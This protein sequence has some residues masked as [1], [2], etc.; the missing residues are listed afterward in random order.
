MTHLNYIPVLLWFFEEKVRSVL[1]RFLPFY[2][3]Y[4]TIGLRS[5]NS[6]LPA[7]SSLSRFLANCEESSPRLPCAPGDFI[8]RSGAEIADRRFG[9]RHAWRQS[10]RATVYRRLCGNIIVSDVASIRFRYTQRIGIARRRIAVN[11]VPDYQCSEVLAAG[12]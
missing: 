3:Y 7:M 6:E 5:R 8:R 11:R 12:K 10:Y 2:D 1:F 4:F 9:T